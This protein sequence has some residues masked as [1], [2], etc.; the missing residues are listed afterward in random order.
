MER[1]RLE[2]YLDRGLSLEQIGALENR[3][4]STIGY[5]VRKYGL[6][7]NGSDRH[8]SRGGLAREQIAPLVDSGLT[9]GEIAQEL[10]RS[11]STVRYWPRR[12]GLR[13]DRA[14]RS[15]VARKTRANG[16]TR[17]TSVCR[18]HGQGD[19]LALSGGRSRCAKCN[20]E[21][22]AARRRRIKEILVKEAGGRCVIC[23]YDKCLAA[24]EFHHR[25]PAMKKF[26]ISSSGATRSLAKAREEARKCVLLR[27]N[28]HA[29]VEVGV[30]ELP[31]PSTPPLPLAA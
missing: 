22:V 29:E 10:D 19:F 27:A 1:D 28:C 23:G 21:A 8:A 31:L 25:D 2:G 26:G 20:S 13:T 11:V 7:A 15:Q 18:R 6:L 12:Y 30:T 3:D 4:P 24:L 17:F 14:G 9:L 5:W 16:G